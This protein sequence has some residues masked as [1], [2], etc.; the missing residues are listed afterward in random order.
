MGTYLMKMW[1]VS[2]R[3]SLAGLGPLY[4]A[5]Q[6]QVP[7]SQKVVNRTITDLCYDHLPTKF[8]TVLQILSECFFHD[9]RLVVMTSSLCGGMKIDQFT[10]SVH[11]SDKFIYSLKQNIKYSYFIGQCRYK[12]LNIVVLLV[13]VDTKY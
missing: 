3:V 12:I 9:L 7:V 6:G 11:L 2:I 13:Y 4:H 8:A 5:C 10:W 1:C